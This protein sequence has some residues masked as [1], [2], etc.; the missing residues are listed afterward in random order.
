MAVGNRGQSLPDVVGVVKDDRERRV[1]LVL[2][3]VDGRQTGAI[4]DRV[5]KFDGFHAHALQNRTPRVDSRPL[6]GKLSGKTEGHPEM[7]EN[8]R[9]TADSEWSG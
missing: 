7:W 3:P 9:R 8:A 5:G 4:L 6:S 2:C 1:A